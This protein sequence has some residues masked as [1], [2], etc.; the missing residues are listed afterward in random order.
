MDASNTPS[1][2]EKVRAKHLEKKQAAAERKAEREEQG[3]TN[4]LVID[5]TEA[6]L[7][8]CR[9]KL[10][11]PVPDALK[12]LFTRKDRILAIAKQRGIEVENV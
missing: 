2:Y 6:G 8:T 1:A 11:G 3:I 5:R 7:Y 9:Y 10:S 4:K 12:G